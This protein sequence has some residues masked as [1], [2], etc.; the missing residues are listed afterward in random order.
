MGSLVAVHKLFIAARGLLSTCSA[1][2]PER[3]GSVVAALGLS[4]CGAQ[5]LDRTGLVALWHMGFPVPRLGIEPMS[6]ALEG[7]FLITGPPGK[8]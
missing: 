1:W 3:A 6:P 7:G 2:A 8:S 4:S 5:A